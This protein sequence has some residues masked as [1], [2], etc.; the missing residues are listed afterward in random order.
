MTFKEF[1]KLIYNNFVNLTITGKLYRSEI[2]GAKV[3]ET[4]L[5]SFNREDNPIFRDPN[6]ST[7]ECNLCNNFIR[8]YGNIVAIDANYNIV[9][10]FDIELPEDN[11][12]YN[13]CK[14]ISELLK[15]NKVANV[16]FETFNELNGLNYESCK[17]TNSVFRLGIENNNKQYSKEEACAYKI[18]TTDERK[19]LN[20][21][22]N[23]EDVT[24][25]KV[26]D[27]KLTHGVFIVQ[28]NEVRQFSHFHLDLPKQF[29]DVSGSS[30]ETLMADYR[31]NKNVFQ[32]AMNEIPLDSYKLMIDLIKQDSLL[33][34]GQ[35]IPV[36]N[37]YIEFVTEYSKIENNQKDNWCWNKSYELRGKSKFLGTLQGKF[38]KDVSE[39]VALQKACEDYNKFIDPINYG[40]AKK[41]LTEGMKKAAMKVIEEL[42]CQDSFIRRHANISDIKV[43]EIRHLN[44][45]TD[46]FKEATIFDKL[47][48]VSST[49]FKR[50][51]FKDIQEVTIETFMNDILKDCTS[52]EL[53]LENEHENHLCNLTTA[54]NPDAPNIFKYDNLFSTTFN[55]N[56]AGKS[57]IKD[58]V[59]SAGGNI[60]AIVRCSLQ[61]NDE[62]TKGIVDFDLH[63]KE[64]PGDEIY[65]GRKKSFRTGGWLD[66]DMIR[67]TGIGIENIVHQNKIPD[68][69]YYYYIKNFC[70]GQ[71]KGFKVE[72]EF[73]GNV[74]NYHYTSSLAYKQDV[75][76]A[77]TTV[78]NGQISI[79]H[80]LP[81]SMSNKTIYNLETNKFHKVNLICLSPNYWG[82]SNA[83]IKQ[84][85]FMLENC[86]TDVP[87]VS[88]HTENLLPILAEKNAAMR[89][90]AYITM[91]EPTGN[92][93]AGLGF[94]ASVR[95]DIILKLKG[96]FPRT[97]KLKI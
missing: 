89:D 40:K 36:L 16:F 74:F 82:K 10:M 51:E 38:L 93:L 21:L 7:H 59:K 28:P 29:V 55:G 90:L 52:V 70:G 24:E 45:N 79:E 67:P 41:P 62:D 31:D 96:S 32:R 68:G 43:D 81:E 97:I 49:R 5:N 8:R 57:N 71:N 72:I 1:S 11:E 77:I 20:D 60:E 65:Y 53:F 2:G 63:C 27:W 75:G 4:Y 23:E 76:V 9:T 25:E 48:P 64:T 18:Y 33:S 54:I 88:F 92:Q 85:M 42:G 26:L 6:S 14:A 66:V 34:S 80:L 91:I 35:Y 50:S 86:K 15:L 12:Y 19:E 37:E 73:E 56:L 39:G 44:I 69:K 46:K 3:Y 17:K 78:K 30:V 58:N 22:L 13:S 87:I 61:W 94:N 95:K 84:Y 47:K 83:G